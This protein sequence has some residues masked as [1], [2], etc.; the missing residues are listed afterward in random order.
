VVD[1]RVRVRVP[2]DA[3]TLSGDKPGVSGEC[4]GDPLRHL[5]PSGRFCLEGDGRVLHVWRVDSDASRRV[6]K[7]RVANKGRA[8]GHRH[9]IDEM[10][11]IVDSDTELGTAIAT[12]VGGAR[13]ER[14][15]STQ[16]LA[17][18]SGVSRS[19]I[20]K[21][22]R[23]EVQPTAVLL[24]RLSGALGLTLSDLLVRA[25]T[26]GQLVSR[27]DEQP[28]W[29]DP[30]SRY[31]RKAVSPAGASIIQV[32]EVEL[33]PGA[34]VPYP[35]ESYRFV[36]HQILVLNGTLTFVEGDTVH[37]LEAGDCLQL[38]APTNCAYR[39]DGDTVSRYLVVLARRQH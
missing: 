10:T 19:M 5:L 35:A 16:E 28:V 8:Y 30:E 37:T 20:S 29:T 3:T 33:P 39:N 7:C 11:P 6:V 2:H 13:H 12:V 1:D 22:E 24:G 36:D 26:Q 21:I 4:R 25:E 17:L 18:R 9:I 15:W 23:E 14:G 31:R 34:H 32:V 27:A 38:G